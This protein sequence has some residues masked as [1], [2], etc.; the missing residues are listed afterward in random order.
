MVLCLAP[1]Q[2]IVLKALEKFT[3]ALV[4]RLSNLVEQIRAIGVPEIRMCELNFDAVSRV[5]HTI[6]HNPKR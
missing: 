4:D 5:E 6:G 1:A 3:V 2:L